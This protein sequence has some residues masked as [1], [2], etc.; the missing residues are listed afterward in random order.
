[1][2]ERSASS[3]RLDSKKHEKNKVFPCAVCG[4]YLHRRMELYNH[5]LRCHTY[6]VIL[7]NNIYVGI[8]TS[9]MN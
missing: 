3:A 5:M 8:D 1:M 6:E 7:V 4:K 2:A 9:F